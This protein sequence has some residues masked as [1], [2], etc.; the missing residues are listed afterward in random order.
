MQGRKKGYDQ[1]LWLFGPD[2]QVSLFFSKDLGL[3]RLTAFFVG[4]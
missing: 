2:F 4:Y 3:S 1:I